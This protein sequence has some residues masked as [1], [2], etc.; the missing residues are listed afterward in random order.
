MI[1]PLLIPLKYRNG[2]VGYHQPK[3]IEV[4]W[5][6][7]AILSTWANSE[8]YFSVSGEW[9]LLGFFDIFLYLDIHPSVWLGEEWDL[10]PLLHHVA[11]SGEWTG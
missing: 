11:A 7:E 3:W 4:S 9:Q 6:L 8:Q 5:G 1:S 2:T 10:F